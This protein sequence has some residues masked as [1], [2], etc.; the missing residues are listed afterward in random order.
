MKQIAVQK[1]VWFVFIFV[2]LARIINL[3]LLNT[4]PLFFISPRNFNGRG[5][6]AE[7]SWL[8]FVVMLSVI[9]VFY[10]ETKGWS[11]RAD[12]VFKP[13]GAALLLAV[14]PVVTG[15]LLNNYI[16]K[17][18]ITVEF[19]SALVLRYILLVLTFT[20][21]NLF[22][23][24][25]P[26]SVKKKGLKYVVLFVFLLSSAVTQDMVSSADGMYN[27]LGIINSVGLSTA[28][29]AIGV[30]K[31]YKKYPYE[32][33][34]A[35]SLTG[36]PVVFFL[37]NVLSISF[38]TLLLPNLAMLTVAVTMY[39][40]WGRK[41][42]AAVVSLPFLLALFLNYALPAVVS[43]ET[44]KE[45]VEK[46]AEQQFITEKIGTVTVKYSDKK[47]RSMAVRLAK[48]IGAANEVCN[49]TFGFSPDVKELV[50]KGIAPG[51]FHAEFPDRIVGNIISEQYMTNCSDSGF[52]NNP[53]LSADFPD[54]VNGLLHEYSHLFGVL[55][56]HKWWPGAEEEGWATYSATVISKLI[57]E[58]GNYD[59][60]WQPAY[61]YAKQAEKIT[62]HNLEGKAVVWS[63]PNEYG[64]F[65]LWYKL[66]K[67]YGIKQLY[68]KRWENSEHHINGSL[69]IKSDP[70]EAKK[71]VDVFGK[72]NFLKYGNLPV[73]NFGDIYSLDDY[74][75]LAKTCG[76]DKERIKKMYEVMKNRKINPKVPLP[77]R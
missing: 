60:L 2:L 41:T 20:A 75:Y 58:E 67:I 15:L 57:A 1:K 21:L 61:D 10:H 25:L 50:I 66:G 30:R 5:L 18:Y 14:T 27:V 77:G 11:F 72:D 29:I 68:K 39:V 34:F 62:R 40:N 65:N 9:I 45:L 24:A 31:H 43:P 71:I 63:H 74:L 53:G 32:T 44:A 59:D 36:L 28:I 64:G 73:R 3:T 48:V 26:E 54:P 7:P 6:L 51:G 37:F 70:E 46:K 42:K 33:I 8:D 13:M 55:T 47:L 4:D 17:Y 12:K 52:L 38:F 56:Y 76:M 35:V 19:N 69:Y 22:A 23:D 49:K 16:Q